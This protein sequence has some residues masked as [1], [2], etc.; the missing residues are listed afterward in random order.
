MLDQWKKQ[1]SDQLVLAEKA[2][3]DAV[4][5]NPTPNY[6]ARQLLA[7]AEANIKLV[8]LGHGVH[9]VNYSTALLNVAIDRCKQAGGA[10]SVNGKG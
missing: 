3:A 4:A 8:K 6:E 9:N 7:D 1:V 5:A 2:Y 10:A